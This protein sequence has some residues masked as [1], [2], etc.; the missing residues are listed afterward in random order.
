VKDFNDYQERES[1]NIVSLM[2]NKNIIEDIPILYINL[3]RAI[4]RRNKIEKVLNDSCLNYERIEAIDGKLFTKPELKQKYNYRKLSENEVACA[5]SHIKAI[6]Y[7]FD[8]SLDNVLIMEDDCSFEYLEFKTKTL[9]QLMSINNDW[10]IIQLG[11]ICGEEL[12]TNFTNLLDENLTKSCYYSLG[13]VAYLVNRK[14]MEKI[15][16]Y[17]SK[18][19]NLKV[20]DEYIYELTNTYLTIPYFTQHSNYFNSCIRDNLDFQDKSKELWD[21]YV[22]K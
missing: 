14:G 7:A 5:L 6:Q 3:N 22:Q 18:T 8:N 20:A 12:H 1:K 16:N 4:D 21:L 17:F 11:I 13:A 15:L 9:R 2:N 19:R 10:D